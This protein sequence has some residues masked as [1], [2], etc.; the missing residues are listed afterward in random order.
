MANH[1][2]VPRRTHE[3]DKSGDANHIHFCRIQYPT[4]T[5]CTA[6]TEG[7]VFLS[8]KKKNTSLQR[9]AAEAATAI[10]M[11]TMNDER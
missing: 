3:Y 8:E 11:A 9:I 7:I 1:F 6:H 10:T 5:H 2:D 4:R